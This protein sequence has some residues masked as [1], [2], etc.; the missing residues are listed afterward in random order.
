VRN[1]L[2][3]IGARFPESEAAKI[4]EY[5]RMQHKIPN[6]SA[7]MRKLALLGLETVAKDAAAKPKP[8]APEEEPDSL[9]L[10]PKD[11][12]DGNSAGNNGAPKFA[13]TK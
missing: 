11:D 6:M 4:N 9:A 5:R 1:K 10:R 12:S 3:A 8:G 13:S 7:A 2:I